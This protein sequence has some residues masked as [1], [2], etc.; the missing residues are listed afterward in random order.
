MLN[1]LCK[2]DNL[3]LESSQE[4]KEDQKHKHNCGHNNKDS[5][6]PQVEFQKFIKPNITKKKT[7][8][9]NCKNSKC[10]KLYCECLAYGEYCDDSCNC[11]D[12]HNNVTKEEV[13]SYALSLIM[14]KKPEVLQ[15]E[16]LKRQTSSKIVRG[17]GCNCKKSA[18]LKK[19]CECYNSGGGCGPHCKCEG[20]KNPHSRNETSESVR[21]TELGSPISTDVA[22]GFHRGNMDIEGTEII[23]NKTIKAGQPFKENIQISTLSSPILPFLSFENRL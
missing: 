18:C 1:D 9:C 19:Y 14:E 11:C 5:E 15:G 16:S 21:S 17:K 8:H 3:N 4:D 20:C 10:L 13:R 2:T 12:C 22:R 7:R 23:R 6:K